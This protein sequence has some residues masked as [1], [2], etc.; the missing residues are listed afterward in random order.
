MNVPSGNYTR[1]KKNKEYALRALVLL[2]TVPGIAEDDHALW[3]QVVR[4]E[5][6]TSNQQMD[7]VISLWKNGL[8]NA[9]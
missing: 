6:K 7:V 5:A 1:S 4:G 3:T 8:L 2:R 9:G